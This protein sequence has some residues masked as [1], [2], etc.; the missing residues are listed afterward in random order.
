MISDPSLRQALPY[1][2]PHLHPL[3]SNPHRSPSENLAS[4]SPQGTETDRQ[5]GRIAPDV[6]VR[7]DTN[8][9]TSSAMEWSAVRGPRG[10]NGERDDG[11]RLHSLPDNSLNPYV[12]TGTRSSFPTQTN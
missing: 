4:A 9:A 3:P 2:S 1:P 12:P 5:R 10:D 11:P 8:V 7:F 6:G